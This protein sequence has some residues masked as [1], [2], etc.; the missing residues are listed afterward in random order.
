M[1]DNVK[2]RLN[3]IEQRIKIRKHH[4]KVHTLMSN[5]ELKYLYS[6]PDDKDSEMIV[7]GGG[8]CPPNVG[9]SPTVGFLPPNSMDC[10][11][12]VLPE[13]SIKSLLQYQRT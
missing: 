1:I 12:K 13:G 3:K 7:A 4:C 11:I 5:G 9:T 2:T 10:L 8:Y 6:Y